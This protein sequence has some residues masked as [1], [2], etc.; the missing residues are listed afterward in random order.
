MKAVILVFLGLAALAYSQQCTPIPS[1]VPGPAYQLVSSVPFRPDNV[2]CAIGELNVTA[3]VP[4]WRVNGLLLDEACTPIPN[5]VLY[6][7]Q[8]NHRAIYDDPRNLNDSACRGRI[9]TDANGRYR[10]D[11]VQPRQYLAADGVRWRPAHLHVQIF[12]DGFPML[13]TQLYFP[14]GMAGS[15]NPN[16]DACLNSDC[17]VADPRLTLQNI[18][19]RAWNGQM[20]ATASQFNFVLAGI[21]N[22]PAQTTSVTPTSSTAVVSSVPTTSVATE[23]SS[24]SSTVAS[25]VASTI[26][27]ETSNLPVDCVV[28]DWIVSA[29]SVQCGNGTQTRTRTVITPASNGGVDC[30]PLSEVSPCNTNACNSSADCVPGEWSAWG[31]CSVQC[32]GGMQSRT[33]DIVTP[34]LENG[35]AC[36]LV[37]MRACNTAA[38]GT[39]G[40][41][42]SV[43]S[44]PVTNERA[45]WVL[46][47][48]ISVGGVIGIA[49]VIGAVFIVRGGS[50]ATKSAV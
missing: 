1:T 10:F 27:S 26:S 33:R 17:D 30:P 38:C 28:S 35:A 42:N 49:G 47:V 25:T 4:R 24:A 45:S 32:G 46:P 7:W 37:D 6:L 16:L 11:S 2:I 9:R 22:P 50:L 34:A 40:A 13:T 41:G 15:R 21:Y 12:A 5:A 18:T 23:T 31:S 43:D 48:A 36:E 20:L 39:G 19:T 8:T 44:Q 3:D 14:D 29:C